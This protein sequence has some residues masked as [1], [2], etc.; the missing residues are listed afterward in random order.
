MHIGFF[1]ANG[2]NRGNAPNQARGNNNY[3][4][5]TSVSKDKLVNNLDTN[6]FHDALD[7]KCNNLASV[8]SSEKES[9]A[10]YAISY[11]IPLLSG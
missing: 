5:F 4:P 11:S 7:L 2:I 8:I 9:G 3:L 6:D 10:F 1:V